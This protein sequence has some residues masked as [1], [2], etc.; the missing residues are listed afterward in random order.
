M[1][2]VGQFKI[3]KRGRDIVAGDI[4]GSFWL[5]KKA[6][7]AIDFDV[8]KDRLFL[9][10][11]LVDRGVNSLVAKEWIDQPW[12]FSVFG[13]HDAQFAFKDGCNLFKN[14][15]A[16]FPVDPWFVDLSDADYNDFCD[17]LRSKLYPGI[18][19]QTP[20]GKV[21]IVH[22]SIPFGLDWNETKERLN[23]QD[24]D[25]LHDCMWDRDVAKKAQH[26]TE[27]DHIEHELK[28]VL[29]SFHGHTPNRNKENKLKPYNLANRYFIDT[30]AYKSKKPEKYPD[31]CITLFNI[32]DP[33]T[34]IYP[35]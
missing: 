20:K 29:H 17:T 6:L 7:S 28:D 14:S 24:Y 9:C 34:P 3:N 13:N 2:K 25:L 21:A 10:G 31:A 4:H 26:A 11:D 5:L 8:T 1:N 32:Q 19:I 12:C 15:L 18:E 16:C 35:K 33:K 23:N 27:Q 30:G 22:A